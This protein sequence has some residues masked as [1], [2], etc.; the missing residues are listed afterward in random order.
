MPKP[1]ILALAALLTLT[2]HAQRN[3]KIQLLAIN[4]LHGNLEPPSGPAGMVNSTPAGGVEYLATHLARARRTN[5]HTLVVSSGDLF[6]ASPLLSSL[7]KDQP[8]IEAANAFHLDLNALGNHELDHGPAALRTQLRAAKFHFLAANTVLAADPTHTLFPPIAIR[9]IGG[10]RIGFI[11]EILHDAPA[12]IAT[13]S[14]KDL[15]FEEESRVANA[16]AARLERQGVHTIV[17]LIHVGGFQRPP[18]LPDGSLAPI[19][20]NACE[21]FGGE[22]KDLA[23]KLSPSIQLVLSAHTHNFYNCEIA[24]HRVTSAGS[25][26]RLFTRIHLSI[27]LATGKPLRIEATNEIVTRDVPKDPAQT[28]ILE[29][30][31]PQVARIASQPAGTIAA[32]FTRTHN[33]AGESTLGDLIADAELD[34]M[35]SPANGSAQIAVMNSGGIRADLTQPTGATNPTPVTFANLYAVQPFGNTL[36]THTLTGDQ[37]KRVLEQQFHPGSTNPNIMQISA[38]FTYTYRINAE[39]GEHIVAM[40]LNGRPI[41]PTDKLRITASDFLSAGAEGLTVFR[42]AT[43]PTIGPADVDAFVTYIK[44]HS[45]ATPAPTNRITR[46]D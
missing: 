38:G 43:D 17:L 34:I 11:G 18:R 41:A 27:G 46:L 6:G 19:D 9:S 25:Y 7:F 16:A 40:Q 5:L 4:D 31:R 28:A 20:P 29:R 39:P 36:T 30:Y 8:T 15:R 1:A 14:I 24:G 42:E 32:S 22:I 26:G 3:V 13:N 12:I 23:P 35:S 21:N 45:P 44:A 33:P 10:V 37:L 2:A